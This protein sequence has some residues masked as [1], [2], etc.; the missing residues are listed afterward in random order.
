MLKNI[1]I[2]I[3]CSIVFASCDKSSNESM[4]SSGKGGSMARFTIAYNHL[5]VVDDRNLKVFNIA[6]ADNP[7]YIK[8]IHIGFDIETVFPYGNHLFIG[9]QNGM[10]IYN[11]SIPDDPQ[12]VSELIHV[13]SCDPVVVNDTLAFVTLRSGTECNPN[14]TVNQLQIID[15]KNIFQPLLINSF[16]MQTPNGLALDSSLI[17]ICH[18]EYGLGVYNFSN[19]FNL[20]NLFQINNINAFDVIPNNKILFVIGESGL[21]QYSYQ[22]PDSIFLIS[23]I[24]VV[25]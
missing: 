20:Q 9:S 12:F 15:I 7:Q 10:Y 14:G 18:G 5:Y 17:F 19:S 25:Q 22:N 3:I 24:P 2:F 21:Y 1:F 23:V 6:Q 11:I 8:D 4:I 13:V 16:D